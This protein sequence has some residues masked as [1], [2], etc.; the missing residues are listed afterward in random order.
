[1]LTYAHRGASAEAPENTLRAFQLAVDIGADGIELDVRLSADGVPIVLHD[2]RLDRTTS[3][4]G[5]VVDLTVEALSRLDAGTG[6][7]V[8]TL[9]EVIELVGTSVALDIEIKAAG[10]EA[11]TLTILEPLSF[12]SWAISSFDW[13]VLRTIRDMSE[14]AVLWPLTHVVSSDAI[15]FAK[16]IAAP[17]LAV[18]HL[19]VDAD[20]VRR[21][22][23]HELGVMAWT[24]NEI[25]RAQELGELGITAVCTD[26]PRRISAASLSTDRI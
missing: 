20:V 8:P 10:A 2:A 22:Q 21:L 14:R 5:N 16:A 26:D 3:G 6:Q 9:A 18:N 13:N 1:M 7:G 15:H 23:A 25:E 12:D 17:L 19:A 11:A 24:V 4:H